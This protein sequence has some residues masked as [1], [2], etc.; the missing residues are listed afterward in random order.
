MT[1]KNTP[2]ALDISGVSVAYDKKPVISDINLDIRHGETFGLMGLNG[3]GKTTL[4]KTILGLRDQQEGTILV[5]GRD[6]RD[7]Q[8]KSRLAY[9]PERFEPPWF[10]SGW[11]LAK[12]TVPTSAA[13]AKT[14]ARD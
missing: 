13:K 2:L 4:I 10:L 8:T 5:D 1:E 14:K 6:K 12:N 11:A 7:A 9:L 3:A